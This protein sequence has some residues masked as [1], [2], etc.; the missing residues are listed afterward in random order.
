LAWAVAHFAQSLIESEGG[1]PP[2]D[3]GLI[4]A[5]DECSLEAMSEI[6]LTAARGIVSPLRFAGASPSIVVGLPAL[7]H[8][9]R[10]PSLCLTMPPEQACDAITALI[11]YWTSYNR[12]ST[13]IGVAHHIRGEGCHLLKGFVARAGDEVKRKVLD[14]CDPQAA[15]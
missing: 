8:A 9:I 1:I 10:G 2:E 6:S 4:V 12:I 7:Q 15:S 3:T 11:G 13:V 5:S 14:L